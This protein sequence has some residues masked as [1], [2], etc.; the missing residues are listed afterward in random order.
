MLRFSSES[1]EFAHPAPSESNLLEPP[2]SRRPFVYSPGDKRAVSFKGGFGECALVPVFRS[3]GTCASVPSFRFF[4]PG[5]HLNVPSFRSSFWGNVRQNH[6]FG[7][8]PVRFLRAMGR[9]NVFCPGRVSL[10]DSLRWLRRW[11]HSPE[12]RSS[13]GVEESP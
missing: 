2:P 13:S 7:N 4:V 1:L 5:E 11:T 8:H 9:D 6:P 10:C 12:P 3:G